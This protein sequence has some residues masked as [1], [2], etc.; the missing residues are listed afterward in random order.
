[1]QAHIWVPAPK[2]WQRVAVLQARC[3]CAEL[4]HSRQEAFWDQQ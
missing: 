1:M 4:L 2:V 3:V